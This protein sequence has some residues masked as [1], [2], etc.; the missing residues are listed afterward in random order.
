MAFQVPCCSF[1]CFRLPARL[2]AR[3][4]CLVTWPMQYTVQ[5]HVDTGTPTYLHAHVAAGIHGSHAPH[6]SSRLAAHVLFPNPSFF[7]WPWYRAA[8]ASLALARA[9]GLGT[10]HAVPCRAAPRRAAPRRARPVPPCRAV[11][12]RA[13]RATIHN[14]LPPTHDSPTPRAATSQC[15]D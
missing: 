2:A 6:S 13:C 7:Q 10:C 11:P 4:W 5:K 9:L 14:D 8:L 1:G 3:T 15:F 12:C